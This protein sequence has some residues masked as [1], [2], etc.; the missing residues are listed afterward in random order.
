MSQSS[1]TKH[2][3]IHRTDDWP[4]RYNPIKLN[5]KFYI[6]SGF[7]YRRGGMIY[8]QIWERIGKKGKR[9]LIIDQDCE[10]YENLE[11]GIK[12]IY[13]SFRLKGR[14]TSAGVYRSNKRTRGNKKWLKLLVKLVGN[15]KKA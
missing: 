1:C 11:K 10:S 14:Y 8:C 15:T 9:R 4:K 3:K 13:P 5:E 6:I 7:D 12:T 2:T